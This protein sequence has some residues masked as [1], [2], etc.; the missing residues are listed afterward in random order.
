MGFVYEDISLSTVKTNH[1]VGALG[2]PVVQ[3]AQVDRG[4]RAR[5]GV[6]RRTH[7]KTA[8]TMA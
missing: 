1:P 2:E 6:R 8:L 7:S 3:V 5:L 4:T